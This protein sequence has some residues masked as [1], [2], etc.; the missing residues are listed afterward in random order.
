[1]RILVSKMRGFCFICINPITIRKVERIHRSVC[2]ECACDKS[3]IVT[4]AE[5]ELSYVEKSALTKLYHKN[6]VLFSRDEYD[7]LEYS[8]GLSMKELHTMRE[9]PKYVKWSWEERQI[10][11]QRWCQ[12]NGVDCLVALLDDK[13][14]AF[15]TYGLIDFD[16][17][18][19]FVEDFT[20]RL[21]NIE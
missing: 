9:S 20:S 11:V 6:Y 16:S 17:D 5:V 4:N 19:E 8:E 13:V 7:A 3:K 2:A 12:L 14:D 18:E 21:E 1:M 10:R 15:I